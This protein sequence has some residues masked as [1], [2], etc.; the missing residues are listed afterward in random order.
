MELVG[1]PSVPT[2]GC[3]RSPPV[4]HSRVS[5]R[6]IPSRP[7]VGEPR[8]SAPTRRPASFGQEAE[9]GRPGSAPP[10]E[11]AEAPAMPSNDRGGIEGLSRNAYVTIPVLLEGSRPLA[12]PSHIID[13]RRDTKPGPARSCCF[14]PSHDGH[15]YTGNFPAYGVCDNHNL[16]N[17]GN[18]HRENPCVR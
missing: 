15:A 10:P 5:N 16:A 12:Y 18:N 11:K 2:F 8:P 3:R 17:Y 6:P 1:H 13:S 14:E 4:G 7:P 9:A